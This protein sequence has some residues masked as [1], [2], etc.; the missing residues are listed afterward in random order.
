MT[1]GEKYRALVQTDEGLADF[2]FEN[3]ICDDIDFCQ[4]KQSVKCKK[5]IGTIPTEWCRTCLLQYLRKE[6]NKDGKA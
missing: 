2:M 4:Q 3:N 5:L 6:E 1:I